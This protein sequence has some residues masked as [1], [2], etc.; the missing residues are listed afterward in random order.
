MGSLW[1]PRSGSAGR[2]CGQS[3]R[4]SPLAIA[5]VT[6]EASWCAQHDHGTVDYLRQAGADVEHLRLEQAG[7]HGNGHAMMNEKNSDEVAAYIAGW[8]EGKVR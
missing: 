6:A 3:R 7:I 2:A 4:I 1:V 5:V 8:I